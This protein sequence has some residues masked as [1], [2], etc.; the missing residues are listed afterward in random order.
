MQMLND[1]PTG[2]PTGLQHFRPVDFDELTGWYVD[3]HAAAFDAFCRSAPKIIDASYPIHGSLIEPDSLMKSAQTAL[4]AGRLLRMEAKRFFEDNFQPHASGS[5]ESFAG[6]VTGY[7]EPEPLASRNQSEAFPIPLY[8]PPTDLKPETGSANPY[9]F[10][11]AAIQA[12]ALAGQGLELV[13]LANKTDAYF[14]HVQ[15]SARLLLEDGETMRVTFAAKTGHA[16]SSLGKILSERLN[17]AP[18]DMTADRLAEWM[19]D[20]PDELDS[21]T[22]QNRSFIFFK[23]LDAGND[24][25]GPI[26]AA[27]I[28]LLPGRSL[29]IDQTQ[30]V[31]G[32]PIW[33]NTPDPVGDREASTGRLMVAH[34]TGSAIKG[35]QRGDI[36]VGSGE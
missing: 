22:A 10:D 24:R 12:G 6:F 27:D 33:L 31:Y 29:A 25:D 34:D 5:L 2:K 23:E 4:A 7:F 36:Y 15:G 19:R 3:D 9:R 20:S 8:R 11:R 1:Q 30:H 35:P 32:V 17:I 28:P 13:W 26:G 14:V 16:Y 18:Q 21:F